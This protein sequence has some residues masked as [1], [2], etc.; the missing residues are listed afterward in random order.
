ME[1]ISIFLMSSGEATGNGSSTII[2]LL[3]MFV[4]IYFFMIRPQSK[5]AKEQKQ[6]K[7]KLTKGDKVITIGGVHGKILEIKENKILLEIAK[8]VKITIQ[9]EAVSMESTNTLDNDK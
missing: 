2:M 5:K 8:D 4:I 7:E 6:F 1:I 3:V 9:R